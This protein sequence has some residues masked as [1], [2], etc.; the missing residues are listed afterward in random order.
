MGDIQ[1]LSEAILLACQFHDID[2]TE[3][4]EAL[5]RIA[6]RQTELEQQL[7]AAEARAKHY[8]RLLNSGFV[9]HYSAILERRY[10]ANCIEMGMS[11]STIQGK[12]DSIRAE[13]EAA[14]KVAGG[15]K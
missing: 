9:S 12:L 6:N 1:K 11:K 10:V 15:T 14:L 3:A 13:T 4:S 5:L 7:A 2:V 8:E